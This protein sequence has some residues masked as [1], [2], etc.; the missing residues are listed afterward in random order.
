M[1][2]PDKNNVDI[3]KLFEWGKSYQV[4]L[5]N[6][7][8]ITVFMRLVGDADLNLA[9]VYALRNSSEFRKKLRTEGTEE[10]L[11]YIAEKDN[12]DKENI[13]ALILFMETRRISGDVIKEI[14]SKFPK[15]LRA[16][17]TLEE[18]EEHQKELDSYES[19]TTEK[20][21]KEISDRIAKERKKLEKIDFET[22]YKR[23]VEYSID[24]LA[25]TEMYKKFLDACVYYGTFTDKSLKR[26]LFKTIE[27]FQNLLPDVKEQFVNL[28][29]QLDIDTDELKK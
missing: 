9:R 29:K 16:D 10:R 24:E 11:A 18:L 7:E 19:I 21:S 2:N 26:R 3:S 1:L 20:I 12:I 25:E 5:K 23:Y 17:A 22:L 8:E 14:N 13:V 15:E 27:D 4:S 6:G 28:Y